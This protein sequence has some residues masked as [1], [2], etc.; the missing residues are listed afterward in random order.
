MRIEDLGELE[1]VELEDDEEPSKEELLEYAEYL[2]IDLETEQELLELA[3]Q[4]LKAKLPEGWQL[5]R[6]KK[7]E[8]FYCC[9]NT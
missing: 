1:E 6:N 7:G 5:K 4:G 8:Y 3:E 2:G 9:A